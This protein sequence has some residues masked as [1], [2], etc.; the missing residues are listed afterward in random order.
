MTRWRIGGVGLALLL[1]AV[2]CARAPHPLEPFD[3]PSLQGP[4]EAI[5]HILEERWQRVEELR[6]LGRVSYAGAQGRYSTRQTLL[7]RRPALLRLEAVS[8]VGQPTMVLVA[9]AARTSVYYPQQDV[10]YEGPSTAANLARFIGLPLATEDVTRFLSGHIE[11]GSRPSWTLVQQEIDRGVPLLRF[12]DDDGELLQDAWVDPERVLPLRVIRYDDGGAIAVDVR[13]SD[14]RQTA[15]GFPFPFHLEIFLPLV[16]AALQIQYLSVDLNP[17]LPA[18]LF[19]LAP[20]P[21]TR[22]VPLD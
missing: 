2:A 6:A 16:Q 14:F 11:P 13:Y 21:G 8:I 22:T 5:L 19:R 20:P 9:D 15:E 17:G 12:L 1:G 10:L 7:W 3:L 4:P 18:S